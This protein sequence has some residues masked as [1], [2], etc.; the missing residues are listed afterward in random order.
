MAEIVGKTKKSRR[1]GRNTLLL[2]SLWAFLTLYGARM[3]T[4]PDPVGPAARNRLIFK[5]PA[6]V[7]V[8]SLSLAIGYVATW[9]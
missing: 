7:P 1:T 9:L 2:L 3:R 6:S 4:V 8:L 5:I